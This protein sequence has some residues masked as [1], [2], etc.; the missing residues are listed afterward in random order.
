MVT[1]NHISE[2]VYEGELTGEG[3]DPISV[4]V[5][6]FPEDNSA[7][8]CNFEI[9]LILTDGICMSSWRHNSY[10][11]IYRCLIGQLPSPRYS[12]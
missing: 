3:F 1:V 2:T 9:N 8:V 11:F 7:L 10:P 4:V 5:I 12:L 6:H